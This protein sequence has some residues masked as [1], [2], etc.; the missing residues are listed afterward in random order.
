MLEAGAEASPLKKRVAAWA[1]Q[2]ALEEFDR[3]QQGIN[4]GGSLKYHIANKLVLR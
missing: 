2:A 4:D 1:K 3:R